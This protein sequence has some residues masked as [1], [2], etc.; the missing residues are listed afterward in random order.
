[1]SALAARRAAASARS[2][3]QPISAGSKGNVAAGRPAKAPTPNSPPYPSS[4]QSDEPH[5]LNDSSHKRQRTYGS[6]P[7]KPRDSASPET[8]VAPSH[9]AG[10][11]N[12]KS[13]RR[14]SPSLPMEEAD[15]GDGADSSLDG[16]YMQE[17]VALRSGIEAAVEIQDTPTTPGTSRLRAR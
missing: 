1:M 5:D 8:Q 17:D 9:Q 2:S 10:V 11:P 4:P 3:P 12:R 16:D 13:K 6:P 7:L 14:V 15:D